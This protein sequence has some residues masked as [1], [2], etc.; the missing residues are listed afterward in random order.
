MIAF[1]IQV[2][3][4]FHKIK[5]LLP[6]LKYDSDFESFSLDIKVIVCL[7]QAII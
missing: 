5:N 4:Y 6:S 3:H 7:I 2:F 1:L